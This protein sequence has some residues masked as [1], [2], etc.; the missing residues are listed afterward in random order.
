MTWSDF[1]D[2]GIVYFAGFL[3]LSL[4]LLKKSLLQIDGDVF[5]KLSDVVLEDVFTLFEINSYQSDVLKV[6][7]QKLDIADPKRNF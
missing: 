5:G 1:S 3:N 7:L 6:F 2:Q 4:L